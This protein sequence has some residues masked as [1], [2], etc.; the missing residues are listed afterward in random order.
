MDFFKSIAERACKCDTLLCIGLDPV[1]KIQDEKDIQA[2]LINF[3][4]RIVEETHTY[5]LC[6]KPNIAFF[7]RYGTEGLAALKKIISQIP[8]PIPC[9]LDAKRNDIGYTAEAYAEAAFGFWG[10]QAVTVNGYLGEESIKPFLAWEGRGVFVLTRTSNTSADRI[11]LLMV[12]DA[13][14]EAQPLFL[15][16]A[17]EAVSWGKGIGLVVAANDI[18]ALNLLR[19][20]LPDTWFLAPGIGAQGGSIAEALAAGLNQD[21]LGMIPV[22]ARHIIE[23]RNPG[24][25]AKDFCLAIRKAKAKPVFSLPISLKPACQDKKLLIKRLLEHGCFKVGQFTLKSGIVSPFYLDLRK[26]ISDPGLLRLMAEA[27]LELLKDLDF[28]RLAAIPLASLPLATAISLLADRPLIYPRLPVKAHGLAAPIDGDCQPGER[29][30]LI[31]DLVTT[32]LSKKEAVEVLRQEGLVIEDLVVLIERGYN[33]RA[34]LAEL[35]LRLRAVIH[36][37]EI[38]NYLEN[39]KLIAEGLIKQIRSFLSSN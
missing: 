4:L 22:V 23:D 2:E 16:M 31:D 15:K 19:K 35:G 28:K 18:S 24:Q 7:E 25:K 8:P 17:Q 1:L 30:V 13:L 26:L 3:C 36:I 21:G 38:V 10:A 34:E 14:T 12:R 5:A 20:H 29:V 9:I 37:D 32:G 27:Y 11:Q 33:A 39:E 6:F